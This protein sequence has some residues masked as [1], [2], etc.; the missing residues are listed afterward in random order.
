M[1]GRPYL[2]IIHVD[3]AN[4]K[5]GNTVATVRILRL[6]LWYAMS[7]LMHVMQRQNDACNARK[8]WCMWCN[9][10]FWGT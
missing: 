8:N 3:H 6:F 2:D 4:L 9:Y 5:T 10:D 7:D 1:C